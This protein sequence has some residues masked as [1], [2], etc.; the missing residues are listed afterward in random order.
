MIGDDVKG[1]LDAAAHTLGEL[2]RHG[3]TTETVEEAIDSG[4]SVA[5]GALPAIVTM[6]EFQVPAGAVVGALEPLLREGIREA[7][8]ALQPQRVEVDAE[9]STIT[10]TRRT[11]P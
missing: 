5:L 3:V 8:K 1:M 4:V 7:L 6:G 10:R 9:R 2:A 11:P